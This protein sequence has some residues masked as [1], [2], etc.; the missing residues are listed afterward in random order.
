[1]KGE[2]DSRIR[3]VVLGENREERFELITGAFKEFQQDLERVA[4]RFCL[5]AALWSG[6]KTI[7]ALRSSLVPYQAE[8]LATEMSLRLSPFLPHQFCELDEEERHLAYKNNPHGLD[9][10]YALFET[11]SGC[12]GDAGSVSGIADWMQQQLTAGFIAAKKTPR[13]DIHDPRI[14][15]VTAETRLLSIHPHS[16]VLHREREGGLEDPQKNRN[17]FSVVKTP[18]YP[19]SFGRYS[20][21]VEIVVTREA[22]F[23]AISSETRERIRVAS[24]QILKRGGVKV[25]QDLREHRNELGLWIPKLR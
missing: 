11:I 14:P 20:E 6:C 19:H 23:T 7:R 1:M 25:H 16:F 18:F 15:F 24:T 22:D 17:T 12:G 2:Q 21:T 13:L 8:L 5:D 4:I 10:A 3:R 9:A